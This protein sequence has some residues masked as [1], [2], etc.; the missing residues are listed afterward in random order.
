MEASSS[1]SVL[2]K[3]GCRG[4]WGHWGC[5]GH[6]G[7]W[8]S[9]CQRNH[10]ICKVQAVILRK[11]AETSQKRWKKKLKISLHSFLYIF[12]LHLYFWRLWRTGMLL[13][14]KLKGHRSNFQTTLKQNLAWIFL[15]VGANWNVNVCPGTPCIRIRFGKKIT[16]DGFKVQIF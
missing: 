1:V 8:G 9:W 10:S 11:K 15:S 16:S 13:L 14:T 5:W 3:W 7:R 12:F 2:M 4:H 6:W